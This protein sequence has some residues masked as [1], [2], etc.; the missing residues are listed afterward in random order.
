M[1]STAVVTSLAAL[2]HEHRLAV[3]RLLVRRGPQGLAAGELS[4]RLDIPPATMSFHLKELSQA[5]LVDSHRDGRSIIYAANYAH[6]NGLMEF[7]SDNCCAEGGD[8]DCCV[9]A[10][11]RSRRA[12]GEAQ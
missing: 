2:A 12:K 8:P 10:P 3:Y 4:T 5:G 9:P 6:M 7:L 1:K 11:A